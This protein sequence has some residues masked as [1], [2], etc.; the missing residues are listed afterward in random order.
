MPPPLL[1]H[2]FVH[3]QLRKLHD[4]L[5]ALEPHGTVTG[6][7]RRIEPETVGYARAVIGDVLDHESPPGGDY[8]SRSP[9][10]S[11]VQSALHDHLQT[12]RDRAR[13]PGG[14]TPSE[15]D[16]AA[17]VEHDDERMGDP[18]TKADIAGWVGD[19]ALSLVDRFLRG[20]HPFCDAPAR[21]TLP[22]RVRLVLTA[23]WGTGRRGAKMVGEQA[24]RLLYDSDAPAHLVHLGDT[25]YS[26]TPTECRRNVLDLWP[27][28]PGSAAQIGSWALNGN[29]D[30]YSGGHGLF[31]TILGDARFARQRAGEVPTSWFVLQT[32]GWNVVALDTSWKHPLLEIHRGAVS[33]EG[34]RGHL[35]GSQ[36]SVVAECAA[37]TSRRLL[38][39][40]H[41][42]LF[43][44]YDADHAL[45][46]HKTISTPLQDELG[47]ILAGREAD[48]WF[49]GH[50]HDCLAYEPFGGV[51]AARAIGHGG[52]PV[53]VRD[54]PAAPV[55][56]A[57][58]FVV[59]P[60]AGPGATPELQALR[61][62]YRD[63]RIGADGGHWAKH[64]L[65]V[66]DIDGRD[67]EVSYVDDEGKTWLTESL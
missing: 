25:Y 11:V 3:G 28:G 59:K 44:A 67:L 7:G 38:L 29:H 35:E 51:R 48:A 58:D 39:L 27:V 10:V 6:D 20:T 65:A 49:W 16:E 34:G 33:I 63:Y 12:K 37:D 19:I 41:H 26:G 17:A 32:P 14:K 40:S 2:D 13:T 30:M 15:E 5:A 36:A 56:G 61:W 4:H 53:I 9:V 47:R 31:Q 24:Q 55:S 46:T 57:P 43:S 45:F 50:E 21:A 60:T 66:L 62:E 42:Q 54:T 52:V 18:F 22:G 64:G 1:R 23:D 8:Y